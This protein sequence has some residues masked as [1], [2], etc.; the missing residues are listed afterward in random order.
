MYSPSALLQITSVSWQ[1]AFTLI[2]CPDFLQE[3]PRE[4]Q[5]LVASRT[6]AH[7]FHRTVANRRVLNRLTPLGHSKTQQMDVPSLSMKEAY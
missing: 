4:H 1:G 5:V 3:S 7:G 6:Y 2:R